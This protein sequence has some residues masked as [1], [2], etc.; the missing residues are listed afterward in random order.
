MKR[1]NWW[2]AAGLVIVGL[3]STG[4]K[5]VA[6]VHAD[7]HPA[8]VTK[9]EGSE[10]SRVTLTEKAIERIALK[11]EFVREQ[12][13]PRSTTRQTVVP[14]SSLIYGPKGETWVYTSPQARTYLRHKVEVDYIQGDIAVL[15]SGPAVGTT[16]VSVAAAELYGTELKVGH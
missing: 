11:T 4:C 12:Q 2:L 8:E 15:K 1:N 10:F 6:R 7:E 3:L 14:Y 9:I 13:L 16:V 5:L